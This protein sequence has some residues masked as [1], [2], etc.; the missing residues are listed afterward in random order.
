[1]AAT[2]WN[3][4][5]RVVVPRRSLSNQFIKWKGGLSAAA[6][7]FAIESPGTKFSF[8][9]GHPLTPRAIMICG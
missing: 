8:L 7:Y 2:Y 9:V 1:M 5:Q 4:L 6:W 3:V